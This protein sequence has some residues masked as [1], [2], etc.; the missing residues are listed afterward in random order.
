MPTL[1]PDVTRIRSV[2][3]L[4]PVAVTSKVRSVTCAVDDQFSAAIAFICAPV[5]LVI[6]DPHAFVPSNALYDRLPRTSADKTAVGEPDVPRALK[7]LICAAVVLSLY[8]MLEIPRAFAVPELN[9]SRFD[10]GP[11]VPMPTLP[12]LK[13]VIA[14]T[15]SVLFMKDNAPATSPPEVISHRFPPVPASPRTILAPTVPLS[16]IF[17]P[18]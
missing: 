9:T 18:A 12:V 2:E 11:V 13:I 1:P 6:E 8:C 7:K 15:V 3:P 4:A 17:F 10:A 5:A 14:L 16:V